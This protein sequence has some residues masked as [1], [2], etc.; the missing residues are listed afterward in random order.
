[1]LPDE[2]R[3]PSCTDESFRQ[4]LKTFL[5]MQYQCNERIR[6]VTYDYAL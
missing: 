5:F 2:R 1:M 6:G 3:D 4:S